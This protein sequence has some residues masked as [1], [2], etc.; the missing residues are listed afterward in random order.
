MILTLWLQWP[1]CNIRVMAES[2]R[3]AITDYETEIRKVSLDC[4]AM[5]PNFD[6]E[7]LIYSF[8]NKTM[9]FPTRTQIINFMKNKI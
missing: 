5:Y 1:T 9:I 8:Q 7:S 3:F 2:L 6:A 4:C